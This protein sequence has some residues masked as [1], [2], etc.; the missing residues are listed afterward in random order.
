M[1]TA[2]TSLNSAA[3]LLNQKPATPDY[4]TLLAQAAARTRDV[5]GIAPATSTAISEATG[6]LATSPTP[7]VSSRYSDPQQKATTGST[8]LAPIGQALEANLQTQEADL[9]KQ[10]ES[11]ASALE[12]AGGAAI[13]GAEGLAGIQ[14]SLRETAGQ[15]AASF[16]AAEEKADEYVQ[17]ART[18][19]QEVL[20]RVDAVYNEINT[21]NDFAKSHDMQVA[22]QASLGSMRTEERNIAQTYGVDSAE[23]QQFKM[24]KSNSLAAVQSNIHGTYAKLKTQMDATYL[25]TVSDSYAKANTG[26][27]YQE[28]QHVEM[29]KFMSQAQSGYDLQVA[30]L[31]TSLEQMKTAGYENLANWILQTPTFSMDATPTITA[32]SDLLITQESMQQAGALNEAQTKLT[33]AQ[34]DQ[35]KN[36]ADF[37]SGKKPIYSGASRTKR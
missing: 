23:Y 13:S 1:A 2:D 31:D 11:A 37:Q 10:S 24:Q 26:V 17:A 30:Q 21:S 8:S 32:I 29:L 33:G 20:S 7:E 3:T 28:Q 12:I 19:V 25:S 14:Q 34:A 9:R 16:G 4:Q 15:A 22:V 36:W 27:S 6:Q 5:Q 35:A 18:R